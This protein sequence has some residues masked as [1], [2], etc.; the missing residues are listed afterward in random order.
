MGRRR[1]RRCQ[2]RLIPMRPL[3]E[4]SWACPFARARVCHM[5]R[6]TRMRKGSW[7]ADRH[8]CMIAE[9][10]TATHAVEPDVLWLRRLRNSAAM[11]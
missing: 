3:R 2:G 6:I 9:V 4:V 1:R 8:T 7:F 11:R 10:R 5:P